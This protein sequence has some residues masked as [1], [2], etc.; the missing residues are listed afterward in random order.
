MNSHNTIMVAEDIMRTMEVQG[1]P[2]PH[3]KLMGKGG[4]RV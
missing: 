4:P 3:A 2:N 1:I